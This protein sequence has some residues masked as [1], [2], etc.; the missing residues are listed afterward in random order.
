MIGNKSNNMYR[1]LVSS[2]VIM[3]FCY[4]CRRS[5]TDFDALDCILEQRMVSEKI[6]YN[7][8]SKLSNLLNDNPQLVYRAVEVA[9]DNQDTNLMFFLLN[10]PDVKAFNI[11]KPDE[12]RKLLETCC[13]KEV[14]KQLVDSHKTNPHNLSPWGAGDTP[15]SIHAMHNN[16]CEALSVLLRHCCDVNL[17]NRRGFSPL[18]YAAWSGG[19]NNIKELLN[20][21]AD[22]KSRSYSQK[23]VLHLAALRADD[24]PEATELLLNAGAEIDA[25]DAWGNTPLFYA[26]AKG[27]KKIVDCLLGRGANKKVKNKDGKMFHSARMTTLMM[28]AY[29]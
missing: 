12:V 9:R 20:F 1:V 25:V 28:S 6:D 14:V 7:T 24:N 16:D 27:N 22:V 4:G 23:S 11:L 21:Q 19:T 26:Y 15:L 3:F 18:H 29:Y 10:D 17:R 13:H 5:N 8:K 2:L